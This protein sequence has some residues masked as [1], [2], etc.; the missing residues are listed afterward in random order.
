[1]ET[2]V[3]LLELQRAE[4]TRAP[5]PDAPGGVVTSRSLSLGS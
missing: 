3:Q 1:M 2:N 4:R 5:S